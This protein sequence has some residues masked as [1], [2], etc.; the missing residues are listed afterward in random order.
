MPKRELISLVFEMGYTI[1]IPIVLFA[2]GGR[3]LDKKTGSSP[4][5]LLIGVLISIIITSF[6]V[7]KRVKKLI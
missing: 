3:W 6:L 1:A 5:F 4:L 7:Y 2:L